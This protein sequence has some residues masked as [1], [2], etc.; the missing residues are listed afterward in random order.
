[1]LVYSI[2][3]WPNS[4]TPVLPAACLTVLSEQSERGEG[5][6]LSQQ[7]LNVKPGVEDISKASLHPDR[8]SL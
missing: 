7:V 1:M 6:G 5:G 2:V 3:G 4:Q 8:I